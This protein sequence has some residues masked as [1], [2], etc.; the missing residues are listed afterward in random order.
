MAKLPK[1][2]LV[3]KDNVEKT[4]A[5]LKEAMAKHTGSILKPVLSEDEGRSLGM[6]LY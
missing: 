5:N 1:Q 3:E 4:L 6:V 2:I